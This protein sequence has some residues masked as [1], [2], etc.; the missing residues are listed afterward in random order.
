MLEHWQEWLW[1][2]LVGAL[3]AAGSAASKPHCHFQVPELSSVGVAWQ[4]S[5]DL[6]GLSLKAA[7]SIV[8]S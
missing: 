3:A 4:A 6:A 2:P 7:T 5:N 8:V 1:P